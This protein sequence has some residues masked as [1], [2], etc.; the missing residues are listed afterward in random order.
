MFLFNSIY[1]QDASVDYT[2]D[3]NA[4]CDFDYPVI[5]VLLSIRAASNFSFFIRIKLGPYQKDKLSSQDME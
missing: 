5:S 1:P 3:I 2:C 4:L